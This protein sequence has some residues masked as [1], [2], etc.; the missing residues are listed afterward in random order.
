MR[1]PKLVTIFGTR[2]EFIRL[3]R[4]VRE[5]DKVSEHF[6]VNTGQNFDPNLSD[7]FFRDLN[8]R[9]PDLVI[10][11]QGVG[12]AQA[13]ASIFV[14]V[15]NAL[16]NFQPDGV[17][18]LG[19]TNSS[20]SAIV[21]ERLGFPVFHMEAGNRSFDSRVPEELNRKMVDHVSTFNLPYSNYA[22]TNLLR[23]G[24]H[25]DSICVTGS[26]MPEVIKALEPA[27]S[28]SKVLERH[29]LTPGEYFIVSAHR[30]E[31]VDA[32]SELSTLVDSISGLAKDASRPVLV[33]AHPRLR[34]NLERR[35]LTLD[36]EVRVMEPFGLVDYLT[37]Q[38][39]SACVFSDSG[40]VPEESG[41]L[42]F[43]AVII[44]K[45]F[46]RQE[47]LDGGFV[48]LAGLD[49][50]SWKRSM[51][52]RELASNADIPVEYKSENFTTKVIN[53]VFSKLSSQA[54]P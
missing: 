53:F 7:V 31:T 35:G 44:R 43:P 1:R 26:P 14:G 39:N 28:A 24:I 36:P 12:L 30:Q 27:M 54:Y 32:E 15:E 47:S 18:I 42:G 9:K 5:L 40:S 10:D 52:L 17:L 48:G 13:L 22:R 16:R 46:E 23:E 38:L 25:P 34:S 4:L 41:Y 11:S 45:S 49:L 50:E 2:P 51:S 37:L 20:L 8:I 33:S 19:D 21:A 6:V 29:G 3:S